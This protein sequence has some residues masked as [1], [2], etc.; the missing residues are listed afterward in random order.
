MNHRTFNNWVNRCIDLHIGHGRQQTAE[1]NGEENA[2]NKLCPFWKG[3]KFSL[4]LYTGQDITRKLLEVSQWKA[5]D[6]HRS[7]YF[8]SHLYSLLVFWSSEVSLQPFLF[9]D[10][11]SFTPNLFSLFSQKASGTTLE[12]KNSRHSITPRKFFPFLLKMVSIMGNDGQ[13][14]YNTISNFAVLYENM[15]LTSEN[16]QERNK[17]LLIQL[18]KKPQKQAGKNWL[19]SLLSFNKN[20]AFAL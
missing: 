8:F 6:I 14:H 11:S 7:P 16:T 18:R 20:H 9:P 17:Y 5:E 1:D 15:C 2:K 4:R 3:S 13:Q 10:S 12:Y 19:N